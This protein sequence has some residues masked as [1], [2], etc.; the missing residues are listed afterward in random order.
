MSA[1][2]Q[3][4]LSSKRHGTLT[5][6]TVTVTQQDAQLLE[7]LTPAQREILLAKGNYKRKRRLRT[8]G[9]WA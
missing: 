7:Q 4:Q 8:L 5:R 6:H 9:V 1:E 3:E 2:T